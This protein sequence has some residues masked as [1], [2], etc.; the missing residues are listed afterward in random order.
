MAAWCYSHYYWEALS[1]VL[2]RDPPKVFESVFWC[3]FCVQQWNTSLPPYCF[4]IGCNFWS[5]LTIN[6]NRNIVIYNTVQCPL[7]S[8]WVSLAGIKF[9]KISTHS[10]LA[11]PS[12]SS[13]LGDWVHL[14]A[15]HLWLRYIHYSSKHQGQSLFSKQQSW[16]DLAFL[17]YGWLVSVSGRKYCKLLSAIEMGQRGNFK[18]KIATVL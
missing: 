7:S 17:K 3:F 1:C 5:L 14:W 8:G 11:A 18:S 9:Q 16:L 6:K 12:L 10:L 4:L 15:I 2:M 13:E